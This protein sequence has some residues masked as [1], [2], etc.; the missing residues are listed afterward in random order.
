MF[1]R[2]PN[3]KLADTQSDYADKLAGQQDNS[4]R[5]FWIWTLPQRDY[6]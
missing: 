4:C 1:Q 6:L 2:P 3:D 5:T